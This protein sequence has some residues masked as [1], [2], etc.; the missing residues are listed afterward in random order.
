[1][2]IKKY[3]AAIL[4]CILGLILPIVTDAA[5]K[6]M[7]CSL[8]LSCDVIG[9]EISIYQFAEVFQNG[10]Y[11]LTEAF[12]GYQS[13]IKGLDEMENLDS[14]GWRTLA[15][16]LE[17]YVIVDRIKAASTLK[18]TDKKSV[19]WE[20]LSQ[21]IYLVIG[22]QTQDQ[23]YVYTPSPMILTLPSQTEK[24]SLEYHPLIKF[25]K[26]EK[27][28]IEAN[29]KLEVVKIWKDSENK[30]KRPSE[31]T[32]ELLRDGK[33]YDTVKLHA[34][35][36]WKYQWNDLS[37]DYRWTILEKHISSQYRVEYSKS[38]N[39]IYV[40]NHYKVPQRPNTPEKSETP[41]SPK[42]E[43]LPQTGQLWWPVPILMVLGFTAWTIGS[44]KK[45]T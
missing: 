33:Q 18:V 15:A 3:I 11:K 25:S 34:K 14:E 22:T 42:T 43:K 24:G 40:V 45:R 16:T 17:E 2:K 26:F 31:I 4:V 23:S 9:T 32:I 20:N 29:K 36:N 27:E 28:E 38:G 41:E 19:T 37:T 21:G 35:N 8:T 10:D 7:R 39:K 5:E 13:K 12:L 1:M 30:E 44:I 6:S